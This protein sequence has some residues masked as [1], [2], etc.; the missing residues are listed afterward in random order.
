M[1]TLKNL[2]KNTP[3]LIKSIKP[4]LHRQPLLNLLETATNKKHLIEILIQIEDKLEYLILDNKNTTND[5][6][7]IKHIKLKR[8]QLEC[9]IYP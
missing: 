2:E 6:E 1:T 5:I 3:S 4:H 9:L 8:Q 7:D